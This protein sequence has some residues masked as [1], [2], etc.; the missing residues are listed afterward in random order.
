MA[1]QLSQC[2]SVCVH[3]VAI[4]AR[5]LKEMLVF[6]MRPKMIKKRNTYTPPI[7]LKFHLELFCNQISRSNHVTP[8]Q[9]REF[10]TPRHAHLPTLVRRLAPK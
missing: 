10:Q 6:I 3:S 1:S 4:A 9:G 2:P 8:Q 7:Y 5:Y